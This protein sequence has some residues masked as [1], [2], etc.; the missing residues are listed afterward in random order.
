MALILIVLTVLILIVTGATLEATRDVKL[1][2][3]TIFRRNKF[4]LI[5]LQ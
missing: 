5:Y 4:S 1:G 3:A 2:A